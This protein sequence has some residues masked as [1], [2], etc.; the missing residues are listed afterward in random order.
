MQKK[1]ALLEAALQH[2]PFDGWSLTSVRAAARDLDMSID[3]AERLFPRG[4][5]DL[6]A[7]LEVWADRKM[8]ASLEKL[9]L[10]S[11]PVRERVAQGV[12][13]RLAVLEPHREAVRRA[14]PARLFPT[15]ALAAG[16]AVW[17]TCDAIWHAAGDDSTDYNRYTKR[18]LLAGVYTSTFLYWLDDR[19]EDHRDTQSFLHRRIDEVLKIGKS[20]GQM[21]STLTRFSPF[22][23]SA[24]A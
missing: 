3:E 15:N 2:V 1:D 18:F 22:H 19:S 4:G 8:L 13:A 9:D 24:R 6:L 20:T 16:P 7:H 14:L 5:D 12:L 21:V 11:M 10:A 23:R 17:R